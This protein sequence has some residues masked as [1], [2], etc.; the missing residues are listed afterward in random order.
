MPYY[1]AA[2]VRETGDVI[3]HL[4]EPGFF[5]G[6]RVTRFSRDPSRYSIGSYISIP[7]GSHMQEQYH[8]WTTLLYVWP[9]FTYPE[10]G[11]NLPWLLVHE[12]TNFMVALTNLMSELVNAAIKFVMA[13]LEVGPEF[14]PNF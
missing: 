11:A 14:A 4:Q 5:F 3:A 8:Q 10:L 6:S 13:P 7:Q 1:V 12:P 2:P 9:Q